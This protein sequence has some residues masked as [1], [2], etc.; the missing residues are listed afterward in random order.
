[1]SERENQSN[2][3]VRHELFVVLIEITKTG[4]AQKAS[5]QTVIMYT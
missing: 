1:M 4:A 5:Y 2:R 3:V